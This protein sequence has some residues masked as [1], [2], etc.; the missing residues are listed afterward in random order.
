MCKILFDNEVQ[1]ASS[2]CQKDKL[3]FSVVAISYSFETVMDQAAFPNSNHSVTDRIKPTTESVLGHLILITV[4]LNKAVDLR[5]IH[6]PCYRDQSQKQVRMG[7]FFIYGYCC[8]SNILKSNSY[9]RYQKSFAYA[10]YKAAGI[11]LQWIL[12]EK[13]SFY[14]EK[15][16]LIL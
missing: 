8:I 4:L 7:T 14:F 13:E 5:F 15:S 16:C 2:T 9:Q 1:I 3:I 12:N 10:S 11:I 6:I